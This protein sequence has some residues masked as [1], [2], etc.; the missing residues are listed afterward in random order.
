MASA[1]D[2]AIRDAAGLILVRDAP[3]GRRVL[4]GRRGAG[5]VFMP[6]KFVFPGGRV[7]PADAGGIP[8]SVLPMAD[9]AAL[10]RESSLPAETLAAA[11]IRELLEETGLTFGNPIAATKRLRFVFRAI[12][13][14]GRP[15][16]FDARFFAAPA[17]ALAC[18]PDALGGDGELSDLAWFRID[19]AGRLDMP[20]VT[21]LVLAEVAAH[22]ATAP[23]GVPFLDNSGPA[24][25]VV[26]L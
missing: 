25:R 2:S 4:M 17:D 18:D 23:D 26:R 5:A 11:A 14:P 12:T 24:T 9:R 8:A 21:R 10:E 15:R 16:R 19:A 3:D 7:D 20:F 13:P 6:S 1:S 22:G